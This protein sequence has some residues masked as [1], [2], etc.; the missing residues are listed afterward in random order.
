ML[1]VVQAYGLRE[2]IVN[3]ELSFRRLTPVPRRGRR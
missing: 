1:L 3:S 2:N